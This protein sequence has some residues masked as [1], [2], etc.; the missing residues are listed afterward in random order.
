M[1]GCTRL[2]FHVIEIPS[3]TP[4][5]CMSMGSFALRNLQFP[6]ALLSILAFFRSW[7]FFTARPNKR[8]LMNDQK[9]TEMN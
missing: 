5:D 6:S 1:Q 3:F 2:C 9:K 4:S 7:F 8:N